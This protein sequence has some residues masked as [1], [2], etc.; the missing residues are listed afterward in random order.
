MDLDW[1]QFYAIAG[2]TYKVRAGDPS[3]ICNPV[4]DI[5]QKDGSSLEKSC[6]N[7]GPGKDEECVWTC[8]ATDFYS[9]RL[10]N[11][12]NHYGA[13]VYYTL[14]LYSPIALEFPGYVT[15]SV[16][17]SSGSGISGASLYAGSGSGVSGSGGQFLISLPSG[18][19]TITADKAGYLNGS[20]STTVTSGGTTSC[21]TIVLQPDNAPPVISG[22]PQTNLRTNELF[23]FTPAVFDYTWLPHTFSISGKPTWTS[24][25]TSTGTLSGLPDFSAI[26]EHGPITISVTDSLGAGDSLTPFI[27]T[28]VEGNNLP[29]VISGN[30]P[31]KIRVNSLF[32][33][34]PSVYEPNGDPVSFSISGQ[35]AWI[36]FNSGN[37]NLS[38][39]PGAANLGP[40]DPVTITATDS[41]GAFSSLG[42]FSIHVVTDE[43]MDKLAGALQAVFNIIL[44]QQNNK[45]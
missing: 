41:H 4:V 34:T 37:G 35:P 20:C 28:V 23:S 14:R 11:G 3:V 32:S 13:N 29:P 5:F 17:S 6:N 45:E 18:S 10:R 15:G 16:V 25:S 39:T 36:Y 30:P 22:S 42:P 1:A 38:G 2:E 31:A 19:L 9:V 26:G 33:F 43:E 27:L 12:N 24:F 8:P 40:H 44:L 21:G 7:S